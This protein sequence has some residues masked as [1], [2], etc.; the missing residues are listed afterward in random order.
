L[1]FW[2]VDDNV[3]FA[4]FYHTL[5]KT[6]TDNF[7]YVKD[8]TQIRFFESSLRDMYHEEGI[9]DI[10]LLDSGMISFL[11]TRDTN[12][13]VLSSFAKKHS[14]SIICITNQCL[15]YAGA[16]V[17]ELKNHI[18]QDVAVETSLGGTAEVV[19]YVLNKTL[20]YYP[21]ANG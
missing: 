20:K 1:T 12:Y 7:Q 2:I 21:R 4:K 15:K 8:K 9:P 6:Y 17:Y 13:Q 19:K 11:N 16:I 14:S 3:T 10:I 5:R 18:D